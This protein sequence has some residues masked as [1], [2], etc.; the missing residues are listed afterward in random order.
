MP[1]CNEKTIKQRYIDLLKVIIIK[2]KTSLIL[3]LVGA[4]NA[5]HD[6]FT[7]KQTIALGAGLGWG[8]VEKE[9]WEQIANCVTHIH[10]TEKDVAQALAHVGKLNPKDWIIAGNDFRKAAQS[11]PGDI[12]ACTHMASDIGSLVGWLLQFTHPADAKANIQH[13]V[14]THLPA[15]TN[16]A[17]K[18]RKDIKNEEFFQAG[19][20]AGTML[21]IVTEPNDAAVLAED[22]ISEIEFDMQ[23][24]SLMF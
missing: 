3:A 17:R 16:D 4:A 13:N 14:K 21:A 19:V 9:G 2:M 5:F 18:L 22:N 23:L 10:Q 15:L 7:A 8:L 20:I 24:A 11:I 6:P 1:Y 12:W